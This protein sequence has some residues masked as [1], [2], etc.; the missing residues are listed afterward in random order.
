MLRA[1]VWFEGGEGVEVTDL[2]QNGFS[3][4]VKESKRDFAPVV[5]TIF[6]NDKAAA[7]ALAGAL[8]GAIIRARRETFRQAAE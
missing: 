6:V 7:D 3:V 5:L 1:N 8:E 4:A 2:G